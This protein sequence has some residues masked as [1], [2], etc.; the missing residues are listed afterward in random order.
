MAG[1]EA[2][3]G[4]AALLALAQHHPITAIVHGHNRPFIEEA[5][6]NLSQR[7]NL[8]FH[9]IGEEHHWHPNRLIARFQDWRWLHQWS[10]QAHRLARDLVA[11]E[12]FDL[13]HH[14][15]IA[16]WRMPSPL[17]GLG[18]PLVWGP[19][20]GGESFPFSFYGILSPVSRAFELL[21]W[22]G[23]QTTLR[24]RR[25][26]RYARTVSVALGNNPETLAA[27]RTLG[28]PAD[29][30]RYLSQS[31]LG[32]EKFINLGEGSRTQEQGFGIKEGGGG[33]LWSRDS[34]GGITGASSESSILNTESSA[35]TPL[36]IFAGG[37]LEGRKG[38]AIALQALS[39]FGRRGHAF[40]FT[41]GGFGPE[42]KHLQKLAARLDF[43]AGKVSLGHHFDGAQYRAEL[44]KAEVYLLPSL[45]EGAPVTMIEAMASGCVPIVANAGGAPMVVDDTCGFV[46]PITNPAQMAQAICT[47]LEKLDK[48]RTLLT[49]LGEAA[50]QR[51][52][53]R[54]MENAYLQGVEE[55]YA[56]ALENA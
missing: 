22:T 9:Y 39:L 1:S 40:T 11:A 5:L 41:Y 56:L 16:T 7:D 54:C 13:A 26:H 30:V 48:D 32:P 12:K 35:K 15:T 18:L 38:V 29:R 53:E 8:L 23:N 3:V 34:G 36:R 17:G 50:W 27:L 45:R 47:I 4:W 46:V 10:A 51:A 49:S 44:S 25:M 20:G 42:L 52:R 2:Y 19:V 28:L 33:E 24:S 21:R 37:N 6:P 55:A 43:G 31:F 14:L